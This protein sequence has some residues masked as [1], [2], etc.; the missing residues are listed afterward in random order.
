[1]IV[2]LMYNGMINEVGHE[3]RVALGKVIAVRHSVSCD[4]RDPSTLLITA[5]LCFVTQSCD[6]IP[7]CTN[8]H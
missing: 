3:G 2:F 4:R 7:W 1:M 5:V 6:P 8:Q